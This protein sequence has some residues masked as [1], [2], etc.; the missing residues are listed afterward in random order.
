[1]RG[2]SDLYVPH[3]LR[4]GQ[5]TYTLFTRH[6]NNRS[7]PKITEPYRAR[8][9]A[10]VRLHDMKNNRAE[11]IIEGVIEHVRISISALQLAR[12][13]SMATSRLRKVSRSAVTAIFRSVGT[14]PS[15]P[16]SAPRSGFRD[17]YCKVVGINAAR[18]VRSALR[19]ALRAAFIPTT[20]TVR[21]AEH[22]TRRGARNGQTCSN[23]T[24]N[25]STMYA[26]VYR[27]PAVGVE[28]T[29]GGVRRCS[30]NAEQDNMLCLS[31]FFLSYY[32]LL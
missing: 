8:N 18:S 23:G 26:F 27:T 22:R 19:S 25:N 30:F 28:A 14:C 20:F 32:W 24:E 12:A 16:R 10:G 17:P 29:P 3:V 9:R 5:V 1:M 7:V 13:S 31:Y 21:I 6:K 11:S 15:V 2:T 4:V